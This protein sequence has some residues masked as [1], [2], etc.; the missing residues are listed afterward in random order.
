MGGNFIQIMD[1]QN[2]SIETGDRRWRGDF[3]IRLASFR[4]LMPC[5]TP[6]TP[7]DAVGR[8]D[9]RPGFR[10]HGQF[11]P[12]GFGLLT[13]LCQTARYFQET[14]EAMWR[15]PEIKSSPTDKWRGDTG[16]WPKDEDMQIV[17]RVKVL[18]PGDHRS[19]SYIDLY[20]VCLKCQPKLV[21]EFWPIPITAYVGISHIEYWCYAVI[22]DMTNKWDIINYR[23]T[24]TCL[25][26]FADTKV[27]ILTGGASE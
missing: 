1:D 20:Y 18:N 15:F 6:R 23:I 7:C 4:T 16:N 14:I 25:T 26:N 21:P 10:G 17:I 8:W 2:C 13:L 9:G 24:K 22:G 3:S 5:N 27:G 12:W 19:T 11:F